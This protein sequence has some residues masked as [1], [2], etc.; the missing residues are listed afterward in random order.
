[1]RLMPSWKNMSLLLRPFRK[2]FSARSKCPTSLGRVGKVIGIHHRLSSLSGHRYTEAVGSVEEYGRRGRKVLLFISRLASK[3]I[4]QSLRAKAVLDDPTFCLEWSFAERTRLFT[5]MLHTHVTPVVEA[6]DRVFLTVATQLEANALV[7]WLRELPRHK[8]PWIVTVFL[9]D[10]WNRDGPVEYERQMAEFSILREELK[11]LSA[12]ENRKLLF[13]SAHE[14]LGDEIGR[15]VGRTVD[16]APLAL[17]Y[18]LLQWN[19]GKARESHSKI[20]PVVAVLGGMRPEKGSSLIPDIF[21]ACVGLVEV[22]FRIQMVNEGLDPE[23]FASALALVNEPTVTAILHEMQIEEYAN[24]MRSA[25]LAIFPYQV[26][27]Y[28]QRTSAVFSEAVAYGIPAVVPEGTWL[29]QQIEEGRAVGI[30]CT[31]VSPEGYAR[32]IAACVANLPQ[33]RSEAQARSLRWR[34]SV[35]ITKFTDVVEEEIAR[36]EN[37]LTD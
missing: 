30:I 21:R 12:T 15:L 22:R 19:G 27:P 14:R 11:E 24:A 5:E 20:A 36:R 7:R 31:D 25:D 1:M 6:A 23:A 29:A 3:E 33:L 35:S 34:D 37:L 2:P 9:S 4:A 32:G 28:R 8:K 17:R 16:I 10:R 18:E 26:T 13:F